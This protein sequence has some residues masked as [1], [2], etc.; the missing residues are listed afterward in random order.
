MKKHYSLIFLLFIA[1]S[2]F[3]QTLQPTET[4]AL[5]FLLIVNNNDEPIS[6]AVNI[7]SKTTK[8]IYKV[9][10]DINGFAEILVPISDTYSI[11][12]K[13]EPNYDEIIIPNQANYGLQYKIFYDAKRKANFNIATIH[14]TLRTSKGKLLSEKVLL[15]NAKTKEEFRFETDENGEATIQ[16]PNASTY[17]INYKSVKNY[18]VLEIPNT[19]NLSMNYN[20]TYEGSSDTAIYPNRNEALFVLTYLDFDSIPVPNETL[21]LKGEKSGKTFSGITDKNGETKILVPTGDTYKIDA[22]YFKSFWKKTITYED[23]RSVTNGTLFYISSKEYER[24]IAERAKIIA[25]R[26]A[27]WK[28][29]KRAYEEYIKVFDK[30]T[31]N[32]AVIAY[33]ASAAVNSYLPFRD[34]I[35]P[36]VLNRNPQWTNKL[37]IV[38]VTSSM[39]PYAEQVKV[40]YNR[41]QN[42]QNQTQFVLFNDG[43]NQ[44]DIDKKI[45]TT[46]GIYYCPFCPYD[47]FLDTLKNV[48][49][50]GEGGDAPENDMEAII[51][52]INNSSN[53]SD[54]IVIVDNLSPVRDISL[55]SNLTQP[56]RI[57]L[58][59][60]IPI[61]E[62]Y[63]N[64][65]YQTGGSIHTKK[66][67]I[68]DFSRKLNGIRLQIGR[69][70]YILTR[71]R[72]VHHIE[73]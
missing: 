35:V 55:L 25:E 50:R 10:S 47:D 3:A 23:V 5:I 46:G 20:A 22:K 28:E 27:A 26:E 9:K 56:V 24:R 31:R 68:T 61:N 63:I 18:D 13:G 16:L 70:L 66:E 29:K 34:T 62:E 15:V 36:I 21:Q 40:W 59:G 8:Q 52:A 33:E 49:L 72:F 71:G 37:M 73:K 12:L 4:E 45:G 2:I 57:I 51:E 65:A 30:A 11:N 48:R 53:Y 32:R 42:I 69:D 43:N 17:V 41:H 54:I 14:Y 58:C 44:F 38:D 60:K 19:E 7:V 64:I 39:T 1:S 6:E 67:D